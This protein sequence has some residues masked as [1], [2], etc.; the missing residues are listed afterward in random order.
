[1][2]ATAA[3][4]LTRDAII[5]LRLSDFRDEDD[6]TFG[7]REAELRDLAASL[8]LNVIRVVIENDLD[9]N[10]K[11]KPASA[12][13][14]PLKVTANGLTTFR[15]DRPEFA[16]VLRQLQAGRDM[17]LIVGDDSRLSRD[18]RD[19]ADLIDA[20]SVGRASV[21]APD[22]DGRPRWILTSGGTHA[23]VSAFADRINDAR[24]YSADI[25]AKVRKGRRR[26][27]G[28]SYGG[29]RRPYGYRPDP[30]AP[31]H[32]KTL[33]V[34]DAEAEVIRQAA[35]GILDLGISLKAVARDLR[36]QHVPTVTGT[37]WSAKTLREVLIKPA[38]AALAV[39]DG[40]LVGAPWEPILD[41]EVWERLRDLLTDPERRTNTS[42]AN[43]P[44]WL[45]S[46]FAVCG[47]C[48]GPMRAS[49][50]QNR[51][52]AYIGKDCCHVRRTA[53]PVDDHIAEL[54]V[55]RLSMADA[56][57]LL[58]PP[59]RPS[60][61][62]RPL[63]GELR[64]LRDR[65]RAQ[66]RMH[67]DGILTDADLAEGMRAISDRE[68]AITAQLNVSDEPDPLPEFREGRPAEAVWAG[69]GTARRRAVVQ[70]LIASIVINRAGRRGSGFDPAT[71]D[72]TWRPGV[73]P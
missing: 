68:A 69:L 39:R 57:T 43:E 5:Y 23:E 56:A 47:V 46:G 9:G 42:R 67:S 6:T 13:K 22:D 10:G 32:R 72:V 44:R 52:H 31:Q 59:P 54:V 25:A 14:A 60:I 55:R 2:N 37:A 33:L 73:T 65:R 50:G 7:M 66:M 58:K 40:E 12:Y 11:A 21:V 49:G 70:V 51:A 38:V 26:W 53:R 4:D 34:V 36:D 8:S 63:R 18:A 3:A 29:G 1:M 64:K 35:T 27:A 16:A 28:T 41:R 24:K 15:T 48:G 19:G 17:V 45:V 30:D 61:D 71:I 62:V 20:V